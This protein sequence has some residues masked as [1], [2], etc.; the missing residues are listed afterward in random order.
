MKSTYFLIGSPWDGLPL[1][2]SSPSCAPFNPLIAEVG[3]HACLLD[4]T[5]YC[6]FIR[7]STLLACNTQNEIS[8][9][10]SE[11]KECEELYILNDFFP[12]TENATI[13]KFYECRKLQISQHV[14]D[15]LP[16]ATVLF[17]DSPEILKLQTPKRLTLPWLIGIA[18]SLVSIVKQA[19]I[20]FDSEG[21][22]L[23][24]AGSYADAAPADMIDWPH[25]GA[26]FI[27]SPS[28]TAVCFFMA[29]SKIYPRFEKLLDEVELYRQF[30]AVVMPD[31][32]VTAD[33]D[34]QWQS[35]IMLLNQLFGAVLAAYGIKIIAN[36]RSG[37]SNSR[38]HLKSI[39]KGV[40]CAS[41]NLGCSNISRAYDYAYTEK[42]LTI[43]PSQLLAY[44]KR[45]KI[46][47]DQLATMGTPVVSY[48]DSH[49]R[50]KL[51]RISRSKQQDAST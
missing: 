29:D 48:P 31:I 16:G 10:I 1:P 41:G 23:I 20:P 37:S 51:K 7:I 38:R 11:L 40:L 32:T 14:S 34:E 17:M 36:S 43:A 19:G 13:K 27:D 6:R 18:E 25:R 3:E 33:M 50:K 26:R 45:D 9:L 35:F 28:Y 21:F 44:G 49:A 15:T 47:F 24:P 2:T 42:I 46:A 8:E 22:P 30:A 4:S 12:Q 39:P 5:K